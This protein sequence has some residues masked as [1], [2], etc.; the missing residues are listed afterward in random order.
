MIYLRGIHFFIDIKRSKK[1]PIKVIWV[2]HV[3]PLVNRVPAVYVYLKWMKRPRSALAK[4]YRRICKSNRY[5]VA[6]PLSRDI[7][8]VQHPV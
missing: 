8:L 3:V 7:Y 4:H 5:M 6:V 2:I 1:M